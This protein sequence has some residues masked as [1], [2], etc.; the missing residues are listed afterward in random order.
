LYKKERN[1]LPRS[2]HTETEFSTLLR[3]YRKN[4]GWSQEKMSQKWS[5]S[6]ET[7]SAWERNKRTP[8]SQEI[9]RLA[10]FLEI[11][12]K[13]LAEIIIRSKEQANSPNSKPVV[14]PE[15]RARWKASYE[16]WG[17]LLHIYRTRTEFN[18]DFSYP[19]MFENAYSI[20]AVGISLNAIAMNYDRELIKKAILENNYHL[21]LCFLDPQGTK[22]AER[23][24]E[25]EY[26][27][28]VL[29]RLTNTNLII[30]GGLRKQIAKLDTKKSQQLAIRVYDMVPRFNIYIVDD[31]LMTVQS[32]AYGRGEETP[33]LVLERKTKEGLFDY[34][35]SVAKHILDHSKDVDDTSIEERRKNI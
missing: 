25:E 2:N 8:S 31:A 22:C 34:Y 7:I 16:T 15:T 18:K 5:Y 27:P 9:P 20:L 4:M 19:R 30:I 6:F 10:K 17:E 23:E 13:K 11:D 3:A 21:Q 1:K 32:Y 12:P 14:R 28:G 35:A 24:R 29:A 26:D 33:I